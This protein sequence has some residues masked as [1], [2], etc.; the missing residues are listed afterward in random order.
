[1]SDKKRIIVL[2][3]GYGGILTAKK[4]ARKFKKS[5]DVEITLIDKKPYH[6]MLTELHEVAAG[7]VPEDAIR[8]DLKKIFAGRNVK[9]VMD[10]IIDTLNPS[11]RKRFR[12][13]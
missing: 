3:G 6:A 11:P 8:I 7:R 4:L 10:E 12:G 9:V 2:G 5:E 13:I 1:M